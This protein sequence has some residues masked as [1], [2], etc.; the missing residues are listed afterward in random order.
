MPSALDQA[1]KLLDR[2]ALSLA[3]LEL[4]L[5]KRGEFSSAE[6][7]EALEKCRRAGFVNDPLMAEDYARTLEERN[8]GNR[9]IKRKLA[10]RKLGEHAENAIAGLLS[11][12]PERA[13][14]ALAFK[15]K[16]LQKESDP[17]KKREKCLRFLLSRG[18]SLATASAAYRE[19]AGAAEAGAA[20]EG[21]D[22]EDDSEETAFPGDFS[23]DD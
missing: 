18:F 13:K 17:R 22:A 2:K 19:L 11:S 20:A 1:L 10:E 14:N 23:G 4:H 15:L 16:L 12:E 5:K 21:V 6:I 7:A 3:E 8:L 9:A